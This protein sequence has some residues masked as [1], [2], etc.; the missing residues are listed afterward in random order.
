MYELCF[1]IYSLL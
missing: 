1:I